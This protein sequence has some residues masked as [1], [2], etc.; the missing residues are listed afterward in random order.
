MGHDDNENLEKQNHAYH[1]QTAKKD[2]QRIF[3]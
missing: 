1:A 2:N 3:Y